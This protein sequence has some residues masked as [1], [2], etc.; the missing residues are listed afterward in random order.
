MKKPILYILALILSLDCSVSK[1]LAST[2][3]QTSG[4]GSREKDRLVISV[5]LPL[6]GDSGWDGNAY[7]PGDDI[8]QELVNNKTDLLPG[9]ELVLEHSDS[10][11]SD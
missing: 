1:S 11:V 10:R 2:S 8:V 7:L 6:T 4:G 3:E 5:F 9:Y